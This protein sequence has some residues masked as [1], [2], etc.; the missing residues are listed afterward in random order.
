MNQ[1]NEDVIKA[2]EVVEGYKRYNKKTIEKC[3]E[4]NPKTKC[5]Y[6]KK[7]TVDPEASEFKKKFI[8]QSKKEKS[9][10][11]KI[12]KAP[13]I[14][15]KKVKVIPKKK[16]EKPKEKCDT[17]H[18]VVKLTKEGKSILEIVNL[19]NTSHHNVSWH[20]KHWNSNKSKKEIQE[21][22]D[23]ILH[24]IKVKAKLNE[25]DY[26]YS[27]WIGRKNLKMKHNLTS[28]EIISRCEDMINQG[29]LEEI[30]EMHSKK[31]GRMYKII[32]K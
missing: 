4:Y 14:K 16:I 12:T 2:R 19:I 23:E 13:K 7:V 8:K 18:Q 21:E 25:A 17:Y 31:H 28:I 5:R 1:V 24:W 30:K 10:N 32:E 11:T 29:L 9:V 3:V 26:C 22:N 20:L 15:I 6:F 27:A